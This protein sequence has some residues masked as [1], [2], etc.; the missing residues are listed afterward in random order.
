MLLVDP[1][2]QLADHLGTSG[3]RRARKDAG[4]ADLVVDAPGGRFELLALARHDDHARAGGGERLGDGGADA[5]AAA[6]NQRQLVLQSL[7]HGC[8]LADTHHAT[9]QWEPTPQH[10]R[11]KA[12]KLHAPTLARALLSLAS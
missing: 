2:E 12:V 10:Q 3:V 6:G 5:A 9:I 8:S 4:A 7:T 11:G 1:G